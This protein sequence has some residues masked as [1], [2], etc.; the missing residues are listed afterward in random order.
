MDTPDTITDKSYY[1][2]ESSYIDDDVEIGAGT[3]IWHFCHIQ[4]G[5]SIGKQCTLGQNVN[6]ANNV[7]IGN[8][9]KIQ[10]NVS[11]YE[12]IELQDFVFCG[13]SVVFTN[14]KNPRAKYPVAN[15]KEYDHTL[16]KEGTSIGA[17]ATIVCGI[18]LGAHCFIASGAVV[19]RD[20][21]DYALVQGVPAQQ[22]GWA[23]ECGKVLF[24]GAIEKE[25]NQTLSCTVCERIYQQVGG[26]LASS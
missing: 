1:V 15:K 20:V 3:K 18:T 16:L 25:R 19:T 2:H 4:S 10:N 22:V 23:C 24:R 21:F 12:G 14:V 17:N 8:N 26:K 9:C 6:V 11:L 13:P 5:A 7:R